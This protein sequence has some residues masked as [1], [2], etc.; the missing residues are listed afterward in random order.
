[1]PTKRKKEHILIEGANK[2]RFHVLRAEGRALVQRSA[3]VQDRCRG[4]EAAVKAAVDAVEV[5][6]LLSRCD[7]AVEVSRPLSKC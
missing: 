4:V 5:L 7:V 3:S 2:E 6:R 1:M